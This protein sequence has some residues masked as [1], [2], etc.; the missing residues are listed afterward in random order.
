MKNFQVKKNYFI[1]G[2]WK[3]LQV[4]KFKMAPNPTAV[5]TKENKIRGIA[6]FFIEYYIFGNFTFG[7]L[8]YNI[9]FT[10]VIVVQNQNFRI[11]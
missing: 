11:L 1:D 7:N 4:F 9:A 2:S 10:V 6:L 5:S 8:V 3:K